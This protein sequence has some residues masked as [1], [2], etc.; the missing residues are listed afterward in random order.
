MS[1]ERRGRASDQRKKKD[2]AP[3]TSAERQRAKQCICHEVG[4][5]GQNSR[6][7]ILAEIQQKYLPLPYIYQRT[8]TMREAQFT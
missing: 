6:H 7:N 3:K 1:R 2:E 8:V 4:A 5:F